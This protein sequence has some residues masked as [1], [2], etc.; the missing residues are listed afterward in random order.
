MRAS[1]AAA[2]KKAV[3]E[4]K[5]RINGVSINRSTIQPG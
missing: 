3:L 4:L 2:V 5:A 1:V